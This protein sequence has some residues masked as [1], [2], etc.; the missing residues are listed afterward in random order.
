MQKPPDHG[1]TIPV[2]AS[3]P[4]RRRLF[5]LL[6]CLALGLAIGLIG[7]HFT[8]EPRW[9]LALPAAL[10]LGWLFFANPEACMAGF[11]KDDD[12]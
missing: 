11:R 10:A 4:L 6:V 5:W 1:K 8:S 9:L 2:T 3:A 12:E 7:N